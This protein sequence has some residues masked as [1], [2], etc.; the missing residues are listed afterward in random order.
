MRVH[1]IGA[2]LSIVF[3]DEDRRVIPVRTVRDRLYHSPDGEVVVRHGSGGARLS[4]RGAV[5]VI[6]GQVEKHVGGKLGSLAFLSG[7][8]ETHQTH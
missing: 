3:D 8:N 1:V 4:G 7:A 6:V 5:G 2:V